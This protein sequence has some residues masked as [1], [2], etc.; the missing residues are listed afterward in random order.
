LLSIW[1][2]K[3]DEL[4]VSILISASGGGFEGTGKRLLKVIELLKAKVRRGFVSVLNH[5]PFQTKFL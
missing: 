2:R 1:G 3:F 4:D 5:L